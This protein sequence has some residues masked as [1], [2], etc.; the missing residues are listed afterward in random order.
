MQNKTLL[1]LLTFTL[2]SESLFAQRQNSDDFY[3]RYSL[4]EVVVLSRHNIRSPLTGSG[5]VIERMTPHKWYSWSSRPSLLSQKGGVMETMMGQYFNKWLMAEG[6]FFEDEIPNKDEI[7]IYANSM[8]RTLATAHY[9]MSGFMPVANVPVVHH[10]KIGVM[11]SIF[12]PQITYLDD[13]FCK[14]AIHEIAEMTREKTEMHKVSPSEYY[15]VLENTHNRLA[16]NYKYLYTVLDMRNSLACKY[17][18]TCGFAGPDTIWLKLFREPTIT[19]SLQMARMASDALILQYYEEKDD[20]KAAF[21]H[22]LTKNEWLQLS[23]IKEWYDSI[24]FT[25]PSIARQIA[26][27][28]LNEI[29]KELNTPGRK[30][31]FL[32]GHDS[33]IGSVLAALGVTDYTLPNTIETKTPIGAKLVFEKWVDKKNEYY[34]SV[35]MIFHNT[36]QIRQGQ[37]SPYENAPLIFPIQFNGVRANADGLYSFIDFFEILTQNK[38]NRK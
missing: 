23:G 4:C 19:G 1:F 33:N 26:T 10:C 16:D 7:R 31:S 29:A 13:D 2:I 3:T 9:F 36:N 38:I 14:T 21:V 28:L 18:D 17:G 34:I 8:Q 37:Y 12:T 30:F 25:T 20:T 6:L 27:P 35:K 15:C 32:C 22:K 5:S 24:L 11:D